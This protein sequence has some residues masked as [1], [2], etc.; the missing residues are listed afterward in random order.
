VK[1]L[2]VVAF[3]FPPT[4]GASPGRV[5]HLA[6][7]LPGHGWEVVVLTPRHPRRR[8]AFERT[9]EHRDYPI[10]LRL[11]KD[12]TGISYWLQETDYRDVFSGWRKIRWKDDGLALPGLYGR[13]VMTA[14]EIALED[15]PA[16]R[17]ILQRMTAAIRSN[18]DARTGWI[19]PAVEAALAVSEILKPDAVLSL[20]PPVSAHAVASRI[21][22]RMR[23]PWLADMREAWHGNPVR[24]LDAINRARILRGA[25]IVSLAPSFDPTDVSR[26]ADRS[27]ATPV[28]VQA[29]PTSVRGRDPIPLLD[30][31]RR[32]LEVGGAPQSE[33]RIRF[34]GPRDPRLPR[35]IGERSLFRLVTVEPTVPWEASLQTQSDADGLLVLLGGGDADRIPDRLL[36]AMSAGRPVFAVGPPGTRTEEILRE[37][38]LGSYHTDGA[39]LAGGIGGWLRAGAPNTVSLDESGAGVYRAESVAARLVQ[40]LERRIGAG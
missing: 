13:E 25:G 28:L 6:R 38:R 7:H 24:S 18:P 14:D 4:P 37:T 11:V 23:V 19:G 21:T 1:R 31:A 30:A 36:E 17:H 40:E 20:S 16:A 33:V 22:A 12:A 35:S 27:S 9:K 26:R 3:A 32:I 2:L 29:G 34:L 10:P 5:R 8:L 15:P 39:S